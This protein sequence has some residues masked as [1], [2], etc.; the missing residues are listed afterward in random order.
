MTEE[1]IVRA[2]CP[3]DCPDTCA[4][5]VTVRD[6]RAVKIEGDPDHPITRGF[7]CGKVGQHYLDLV[8]SP[9][10]VLTPRRRVGPKGE[11]R[12]AEITWDE[13]IAEIVDRFKA[14][15]AEYGPEAILPY[16]YSGTLG[17]INE[18][19]MDRR[20]F[21]RLGASRLE[22]TICSA[23]GKAGYRYTMGALIGTDPAAFAGA[24]LILF[25]GTNPV[26]SNIH[27]MPFVKEAR[28]KGAR[29]IV[30]DPRR[31]RS[32]RLADWHIPVRPGTDAALALA[33]MHVII[34]ENLYDADYVARHT[35][36][37][38]QLRQRVQEYAPEAVED[39]TGVPAEDVRRLAREYATTRPAAIRISYG[40]QR[41]TN[42]GM[43]VRTVACLPALVGAW[44]DPSGGLLLSTSGAFRL[45][46]AALQREDLW[47]NG[48]PRLV[49]MNQ[50]GQALLE[51]HAPPIKALF[52]YDS[53]PAASAPDSAQVIRGLLRE[54]LFTVVHDPF[55]T[56]T[57]DYADIVLPA[58][59]QL[60][61]MDLHTSYGHYCLQ[62]NMPA[63]APLG[64]SLSN[65]EV[66]RRLA[67]AMGFTE[68][69]FDDT[70]E[71]M[72]RQALGEV[73]A[74]PLAASTTSGGE[75]QADASDVDHPY[76]QGITFER[77]A[78]DGWV[79]L[80]VPED[81]APFADGGFGT[82]SGKVEFYS[83]QMAADGYDPLPRHD[84]L[85]ESPEADPA[86]AARYPL[87]L[88]TPSAHF[89]LNSSFAHVDGLIAKQGEP[90]IELNPEDA[91]A[92]G[93]ADGDW[94][95][96]WNDRGECLLR[97]R[98]DAPARGFVE[99]VA[100]RAEE[101]ASASVEDAV[102][103][104]VAAAESIWWSKL[105]PVGKGINQL[106]SQRLTDM[107]RGATFYTCLVDVEKADGGLE[108]LP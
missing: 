81:W 22:R 83:E 18:G 59:T 104:G 34:N 98:V 94:V 69:C 72:I 25:W 41:H 26:T 61:H 17:V 93:I 31:T 88:I 40:L 3:H 37:F 46:K 99:D 14:I 23:A 11:G 42:G 62:L 85:A 108:P 97:A 16:S 52:V 106:T 60:E 55:F 12:F 33:M 89:F 73:S 103:P 45:N 9:R 5:L 20:F 30:I 78:R 76:M 13:A 38:D 87:Q 6:G 95:R 107:G 79:R 51:L 96:V 90:F 68:P 4:M 64:Q 35:M 80:N 54:D 19:A 48:P 10:R 100:S 75:A 63:I 102:Q 71:D 1:K 21:N 65:V 8:Y 53:N 58:T 32:A 50:L 27:L 29:L 56:D 91:A 2:A 36:G 24:R 84:P 39:V 105:S 47:P 49:N 82:P 77:L 66:F 70:V 67:H 7:L 101:R 28:R 43:M 44:R 74:R 57:T 15:I 86:L 92:R